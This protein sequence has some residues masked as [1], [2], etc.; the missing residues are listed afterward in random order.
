M[1][2]PE[3]PVDPAAGP[4]EHF[5]FGLRKL[6]QEAGAPTYRAM[7]RTAGYST[8]ALS[9][10]AAGERLPSLPVALAYVRA[11]HG[12][13][14][15]W[16]RRWRE[17][18]RAAAARPVPEDDEPADPPYRGLARYDT[19]DG[20]RFFGR[21]ELTDELLR[22]AC[23]HR[24]TVVL[25][26]SGSGKSSLLRAGLIPRLRTLDAPRPAAVRVLTP[27]TQLLHEHAELFTPAGE[28][29]EGKGQGKP[30]DTWLIVD[31]FEEVF[32]LGQDPDA[33]AA[34]IDRVLT[35]ENPGSRI[36]VVVGVRADF[37]ARCL[38]HP[39]LARAVRRASLPVGPMTPDALREVIVK[40]AAAQ[41]LVVERALTARLVDE[42]SGE[43][44]GLPLLSH[45]LLETWRRRKGRMLTLEAYEAAG[46]VHEA[47]ARTAEDVYTGASAPQRDVM[48]ALFT[49]LT[50]LG[51]GTE[52][53]RRRVPLD[54]LTGL[55]D[56]GTLDD[57]LHRLAAARLLVLADGTVE[58]AHEAVIRAWPR[59]RRWIDDDRA[60]LRVHRQLTD[61]AHAWER[62]GRDPSALH[63][64]T[65]L[66]LARDWAAS[67]PTALSRSERAF[68]D[69]STAAE[70]HEAAAAR[71]RTRRL[72]Q[73]V[74]LLAALAVVAL[75]TTVLAVR[76]D[77][78]ATHE[79]DTA[80]SQKV[81]AQAEA[82]RVRDP[83]LSV[84]LGLAAYRLVPTV[85][86]R[87]AL[88][89]AF[90]TPYATRLPGRT[91]RDAALAFSPRGHLAAG[92]ADDRTVR[93]WDLT[94]PHR[95]R[96]SA[97]L[98]AHAD[99]VCGVAFGPD[100]RT[101]ATASNDRTVRLWDVTDPH[102]PRQSAALPA[103][104]GSVCGLGF[105]PDGRTLATAG[106]DGRVELW[107]AGDPERPDR[108]AVL[109]AH[110][111][112]VWS[113]AFSPDGH[114][115]VTASEDGTVRLWDVTERGQPAESAVLTAHHG[116]VWPAAFS[117]DGHTLATGGDDGT[118][119]LWNVTDPRHPE[120]SSTLTGH[121][122]GVRA[123]AFSPD[124]RTLATGSR[125]RTARLWD[126]TDPHRP[127]RLAVLPGHIDAVNGVT[128]SPD[129][130]TLATAGQDHTTRLWDL[131]VPALTGHTDYVFGAAFSPDGRTLVTTGQDRTTRLWDLTH[132]PAP[133]Q[134]AVLTGHTDNVYNA[135][136]SP[137]GRLLAT[138]SEDRTVLLWD[139]TDRTHPSALARI[140]A[141]T[142]N[143]EGVAFSPDGRILATT[144][145]DRTVRLW[146]L[147]DPQHPT[148]LATLTEHTAPVRSAAFSPDGRTL[149]TAGDDHS[150]R[151]WDLGAP[152]RP[153]QSAVL[154][155]HTDV[156]R[157]VAFSPDGR[158]LASAGDDHTV[159]LWDITD[160]PHRLAVLTGHTSAVYYLAFS[161]DGRTLA[162]AGDDRTAR[163]WNTTTPRHPTQLAVLTGHTDR[164]HRVAFSPDGHTLA[165]TSRDRTVL[166]WESD[167]ARVAARVCAT[168][169]PALTR[170]E[171]NHYFPGIP[172]RPPC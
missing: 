19:G 122:E 157:A 5:A 59:L 29:P 126:V 124:G 159:R 105:S 85:E 55:T 73:L 12:D 125:D 8:T 62:L 95:P 4:V 60:G 84:Q 110:R 132:R 102:R 3:R 138:T 51:E 158:A 46:G 68:L 69:A 71:R 153:R 64:G 80:L 104:D 83:A 25:G 70:E 37:Y 30:G 31:Q 52:D 166:L 109:T 145:Q 92:A 44:G 20:D 33:R 150:V 135:A 53:T 142:R 101:L 99:T 114:T 6:R 56:P 115:L 146:N 15:E 10:A 13:D 89:S 17:A 117:P 137:D 74:A 111:D 2:R 131:P 28:K 148:A 136:F 23:A 144:G 86:A 161:P 45:A 108:S 118:T 164:L 67:H 120:E 91:D 41:G 88:L 22:L 27:G 121:S 78:T 79:R 140:T 169:H 32:T 160:H 26:P 48:H 98:A 96:E 149:A 170:A 152:D 141:H 90:S 14:T 107:D 119:R 57:L 16:E 40:S 167:P 9:Q 163:L 94:D 81:A 34:F 39:G 100:G 93:L 165:T 49:R 58:V 151:L 36:R 113:A 38:E 24:V 106:E 134:L 139:L 129:G 1:G 123:A 43:P 155:E 171:W 66:S 128:F 50:A 47:V 168:A 162:S 127:D 54:E 72:R 87:G 133:S 154:A 172:F 156:V 61:A 75:G 130:R 77:R 18:A 116:K 42:A 82:L 147:T 35:A 103:R 76:A 112:K 65:R 63:R 7:S 97:T 21:T 11:C 143:P